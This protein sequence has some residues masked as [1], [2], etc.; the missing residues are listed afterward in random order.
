VILDQWRLSLLLVVLTAAPVAAVLAAVPQTRSPERTAL[1]VAQIAGVML[2]VGAV[3]FYLHWRAR[4]IVEVGWMVAAGVVVAVQVLAGA[5]FSLASGVMSPQSPWSIS[6]D[7][8]AATV[9]VGLVACRKVERVVDPLLLGLGLGFVLV[10]LQA[11]PRVVPMLSHLPVALADVALFVVLAACL[12]FARTLLAERW[13]PAWAGS[14]LAVAVGLVGVGEVAQSVRW[15]EELAAVVAGVAL[16]LAAALWSGAT[17]LLARETTEAHDRRTAELEESLHHL[18]ADARA[19][20]EHLH[21]VRSTLA[22]V[23]SATRLLEHPMTIERRQRLERTIRAELD[24]LER[25]LTGDGAP[26]P[27]PVDLDETLDVLLESHRAR[28]RRIEWE[29][30]GARVHGDRDDVAEV[31]NILLDNAAKHG[32]ADPSHVDVSHDANEIRIAVRD[33]GPGVPREMRERIF[34][35]GG[36]AGTAPGQGI[37]LHVARRLVARH[38]GSLTLADQD[39]RGSAFVVRLPAALTS[40]D[41]HGRHAERRA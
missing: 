16:V 39:A 21:E 24:R 36:R 13:L 22:G 41:H 18:E 10:G 25:L 15:S 32:G 1:V 37:G 27:G 4:P 26:E 17:Y 30:C 5:G 9:A 23:A 12:A 29:P 19:V 35:W 34:D 33:G 3:L 40:E 20:H 38:G 31:L 8:L 14:R 7:A 2:L 28:G 11:L 6:L